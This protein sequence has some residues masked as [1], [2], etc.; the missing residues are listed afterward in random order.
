MKTVVYAPVALA[1]L[2]D[3]FAYTIERFGAAQADA[4][5]A[6]LTRRLT[7][8][9]LGR[10]VAA[11]PCERLMRDIREATGLTYIR[12]GSHYLILRERRETL[13]LVEVIHERMNIEAHLGRLLEEDPP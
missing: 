6:R 7:D 4:Y 1:R 9:A 13:E 8:L 5:A 10:G 3:I 2:T 11:R 12:E